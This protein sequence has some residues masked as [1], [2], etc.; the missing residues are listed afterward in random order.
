MP[1]STYQKFERD[2]SSKGSDA[3]LGVWADLG[4]AVQVLAIFLYVP[5]EEIGC[6]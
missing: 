2:T 1:F 3:K 4:S 5:A 6:S